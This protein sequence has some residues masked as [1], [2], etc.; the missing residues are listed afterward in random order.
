MVSRSREKKR[1]GF[2]RAN[3]YSVP[4]GTVQGSLTAISDHVTGNNEGRH[5]LSL[6]ARDSAFLPCIIL[7]KLQMLI[8]TKP[9]QRQRALGGGGLWSFCSLPDCRIINVQ[10]LVTVK[11]RATRTLAFHLAIPEAKQNTK[12]I[13]H[14]RYLQI[15]RR[16]THCPTR[17]RSCCIL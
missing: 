5:S 4:H 17:N 12:G 8:I 10:I 3:R 2:A 1:F 14:R 6:A 9:Q 15:L 11:G 7:L 13:C 16:G